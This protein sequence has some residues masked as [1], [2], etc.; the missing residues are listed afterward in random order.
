MGCGGPSK[1][2]AYE[3]DATKAEE[4]AAPEAKPEA[5]P[6][7]KPSEK[8]KKLTLNTVESSRERR[9]SDVGFTAKVEVHDQVPDLGQSV[10]ADLGKSIKTH[11]EVTEDVIHDKDSLHEIRMKRQPT[12][13]SKDMLRG[14]MA[15]RFDDEDEDEEEEAAA[16]A[17]APAEAEP[18]AA[19]E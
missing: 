6:E 19:T 18:A 4:A 3:A 13:T 17:E 1:P 2:K 12:G 10:A 16:E 9:P 11:D 8:E 5:K 14:A 7:E 15:A